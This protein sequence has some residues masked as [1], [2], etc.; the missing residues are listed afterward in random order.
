MARQMNEAFPFARLSESGFLE[1]QVF[2]CSFP[3][4]GC[5]GM[6]FEVIRACSILTS[7]F[8]LRKRF[9]LVS[10]SEIN[11]SECLDILGGGNST[12]TEQSLLGAKPELG[13]PDLGRARRALSDRCRV[14]GPEHFASALDWCQ[15]AIHDF[16]LAS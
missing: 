16:D 2:G 11:L 8:I 3:T 10:E 7:D 6:L 4:S 1:F 5:S 12:K 9:T 15:Q 14:D 13:Q